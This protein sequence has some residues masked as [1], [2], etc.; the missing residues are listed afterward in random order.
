[1]PRSSHRVIAAFL[2]F[3]SV[4]ACRRHDAAAP[5]AGAFEDLK[6]RAEGA[7]D[8]GHVIEALKLYQDALKQK[9]D[10]TEGQ[11]FEGL[12]LFQMKRHAEARDVFQ[13]LVSHA[14]D[15]GRSWAMKGLCEFEMGAYDTARTDLERAAERGMAGDQRTASVAQYHRALLLTRAGVFE[16]AFRIL[17]GLVPLDPQSVAVT[18]ALG[19]NRLRMKRLPTELAAEQRPLVEAV[20]RATVLM[21]TQRRAEARD[22]LAALV[23]RHPKA[24]DVHYV[25][26]RFLLPEERDRGL[27]ELQQELRLSPQHAGARTQIALDHLQRGQ[28]Q[29]ALPLAREAAR[30]EPG[31]AEARS[32]YGRALAGTGAAAAAIPELEAALALDA[33]DAQA[34]LALS[35]AYAAVGRNEDAARESGT[36]RQLSLNAVR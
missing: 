22:E 24:P 20:G 26:G 36:S 29:K 19:I 27:A 8:A 5:A 34:H 4:A 3:A 21:L 9:P 28:A 16:Q 10:W 18:W 2:L 31:D 14:P 25:F 7:R 15:D 30:R 1:V 6:A 12:L 11:W 13:R 32:T 17:K 35:E 33:G 23:Q